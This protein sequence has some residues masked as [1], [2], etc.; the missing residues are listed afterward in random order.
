MIK[1]LLFLLSICLS[2]GVFAQTNTL[3]PYS[4][5]GLGDNV[6]TSLAA[7]SSMGGTSIAML[8]TQNINIYNPA[9]LVFVN[10]PTFNFEVKT[11]F[12]TL[13]SGGSAETSSLF[14]IENFSFAFPLVVNPQRKRKGAFTFGI[15]PYARQGYDVASY[16]TV[17]EIGEIEYRFLGEGGIN[18]A[19]LAA[20]YELLTDSGR[21]N[22][23]AF[24]A[25][26]SYVF[27][28]IKNE[29]ITTLDNSVSGFGSN[30]YRGETHEIS[31]ADVR[32]G[33]LYTR[34]L[35]WNNN[36]PD[37][38]TGS[39]SI[40]AFY[41]P[42]VS[43]NTFSN[44]TAYTF[45]NDFNSP[46]I[47]DTVSFSKSN[48]PTIAA[49]SFGLGF[50]FIYDGRISLGLDLTSTRWS[51]LSIAGTNQGLNDEM[52]ASFGFEYIPDPTSYKQLIKVIRYRAGFSY[53]QTRLNVGGVQPTRIGLTAGLGVPIIASKSTSI[54][55]IGTEYAMRSGA[56][57]P[58]TE[59]YV[60]FFIGLTFTP[61]QYD[62]W[63][64]K[65]KYD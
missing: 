4:I 19:F 28:L 63:F 17:P 36:T 35:F 3:S 10:R 49:S 42:S 38:K 39:V 40:G 61:N 34:R 11:E 6:H 60:N 47:I 50:G 16:E 57:L 53:E 62:R 55:N 20:G 43:L 46:T 54:F 59:N 37:A 26:G 52:R 25:T 24:G 8:S 23:L 29:R 22:T 56:G 21:V 2:Q 32:L 64:A 7:Q 33:L 18:S 41:K 44:Q 48:I 65:Q 51:E 14:S 58:V 5:Y 30:L 31:A 27:G 13:N 1:R 45:I 12:L 15:T 9:T